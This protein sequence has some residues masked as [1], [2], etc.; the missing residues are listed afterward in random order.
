MK[1]YTVF[2]A[3][4]VSLLSDM[5]FFHAVCDYV[6]VWCVVCV[7]VHMMYVCMFV[8]IIPKLSDVSAMNNISQ[9]STK[10]E[11][12]AITLLEAFSNMSECCILDSK[13]PAD[14][15]ILA[16][17]EFALPCDS[18]GAGRVVP[19]AAEIRAPLEFNSL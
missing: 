4:K 1:S 17:D 8:V 3:I 18:C 7:C 2:H 13:R 11:D 14:F 10:R 6:C 19:L 5:S 12:I 15:N 9:N 16:C